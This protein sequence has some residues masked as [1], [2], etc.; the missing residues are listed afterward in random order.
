LGE[1][2]REILRE[3]GYPEATID[4]MVTAG[5]TKEP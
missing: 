2:S 3:A 4:A 1:H 5:V